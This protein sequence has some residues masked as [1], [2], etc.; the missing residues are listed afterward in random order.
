MDT[1]RGMRYYLQTNNLYTIYT[2]H[3]EDE[4][5]YFNLR[6]QVI[7]WSLPVLGQSQSRASPTW[8][9]AT[10]NGCN[11]HREREWE[12]SRESLEPPSGSRW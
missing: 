4:G 5:T 11:H 12:R 9:G 6:E 3:V 2:R 8:I 7:Q 1:T 10:P